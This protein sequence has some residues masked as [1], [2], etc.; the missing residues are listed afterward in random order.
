MK[1]ENFDSNGKDIKSIFGITPERWD[2]VT[3]FIKKVL[4]ESLIKKSKRSDVMVE[5]VE[6]ANTAIEAVIIYAFMDEKKKEFEKLRNSVS[7]MFRKPGRNTKVGEITVENGEI[8]SITGDDIPDEFIDDMEKIVK[9]L[10][11]IKPTGNMSVDGDG[12][13]N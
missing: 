6:F 5:V 7:G 13:L 10:K 2:E 1:V 11:E 8:K 12:N 4:M 3:D 9:Q